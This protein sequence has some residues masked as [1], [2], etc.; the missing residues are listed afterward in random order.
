[1]LRNDYR[2]NDAAFPQEIQQIDVKKSGLWVRWL[3]PDTVD[4]AELDREL[5]AMA[6][7]GIAGAEIGLHAAASTWGTDGYWQSLMDALRAAKKYGLQLDFFMTVGTL[8]LPPAVL[9]V[10]SDAAEK[11]LYYYD[12][13][14]TVPAAGESRV[15]VHLGMPKRSSS[16]INAR[17]VAVS[18]ARVESREDLKV[19]LSVPEDGVLF[20]DPLHL[21]HVPAARTHDLPAFLQASE[22]EMAAAGYHAENHKFDMELLEQ[23]PEILDLTLSM[24]AAPE[25]TDYVLF[26]YW[27][28]PSDKTFGGTTQYCCDHYSILGTKAVTD[29]YDRAVEKYP[30]LGQLLREVGR[31]FF[32]DSLENNGNWTMLIPDRYYQMYGR[33]FTPYLFTI[34][35]APWSVRPEMGPPPSADTTGMRKGSPVEAGPEPPAFGLP[36]MPPGDGSEGQLQYVTDCAEKLR[37][38]YYE[39][40]TQSF[41]ENHIL[42]YQAWAD[43]FDMDIRYQ[44]TY[45]QKMYMAEVSQYIDMAETESLAYRDEIDGYRGQ[46]GAVHM[47]AGGSGILSSEQGENDEDQF[48]TTTWSGDFLWRS[49]RFYAAGGNQLVYHVFSCTRYDPAIPFTNGNMVWPGFRPQPNVGDN[50]QFNRPSMSYLNAAYSGYIA[51][52]QRMLRTGRARVDTAIFWHNY[53]NDRWDFDAFNHDD[54]LEKAGYS[55]EFLDPSFLERGNAVVENGVF[56]PDGPGYRA[57]LFLNQRALP[58]RAA[59]SFLRYARQGFP[60]I[61]AGELPCE[62][63]WDGEADSEIAEIMEE[64][65]SLPSVRVVSSPAQWPAALAELGVEPGVN[66]GGSDLLYAHRQAE[67]AD[68]YFLC[69]QKKY[70]DRDTMWLPLPDIDTRITLLSGD[71]GRKPYILNLWSGECTPVPDY[72]EEKGRICLRLRLKGAAA[73]ALVLAGE[74]WAEQAVIRQ[75][76]PEK[77]DAEISL[78]DWSLR[79]ISFEP[80]PAAL[81]GDD[82]TDTRQVPYELGKIGHARP[83]TQLSLPDGRSGEDISGVAVYETDFSFDGDPDSRLVLDLGSVCDLYALRVNGQLIPGA[84]PVDPVQEITEYLLPGQNRI[85]VE[86]AS[87]FFHAERSRNYLAVNHVKRKVFTAWDFGILGSPVL[88]KYKK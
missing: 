26:A 73:C 72:T 20:A 69:N 37:R 34:A 11:I 9:P 24:P 3:W 87:N 32:C 7:A 55:S 25:D 18:I 85:T 50:L 80:G 46:A 44:S 10:D 54:S 17:L 76:L 62:A 86:V 33:D 57:F 41:I 21:A 58:V 65:C 71:A 61:F 70:V 60:L 42:A 83:W 38:S 12:T 47:N 30:E 1:M 53:N 75:A 43:R 5:K 84:C 48:H 74:S 63:A 22:E 2:F 81:S 16:T 23:H 19:H 27:E 28:V 15:K 66:P 51:R 79:L 40:M 52:T 56:A 77:A 59:R 49:S 36:F 31:A 6:D 29:C 88:R 78:E 4:A 39:A 82:L 8:C 68:Y 14:I 45:G 67:N 64:L 13:V 35:R